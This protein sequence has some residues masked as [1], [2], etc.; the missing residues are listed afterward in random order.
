VI[1]DTKP[2]FVA[3]GSLYKAFTRSGDWD[4]AAGEARVVFDRLRARH[5][6]AFWLEHHMP[7]AQDGGRKHTPFGSSVWEWWASH[8]RVLE[9]PC[10]GNPTTPYRFAPFRGDRRKVECPVG[11]TRG[12]ASRGR[13]SGMRRSCTCSPKPPLRETTTYMSE[14]SNSNRDSTRCV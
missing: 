3:L 10:N 11:F 8:G 13:R 2:A 5:Q 4:Q 14:M 1:G 7:K 6:I 12:G 9:P